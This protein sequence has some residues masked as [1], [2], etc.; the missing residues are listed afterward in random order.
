MKEN[1]FEVT[2][3]HLHFNMLLLKFVVLEYHI[4]P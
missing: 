1:I 4:R 3:R 2:R